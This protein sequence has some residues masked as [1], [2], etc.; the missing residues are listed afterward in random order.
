[1]SDNAL[2]RA[3]PKPRGFRLN[4]ADRINREYGPLQYDDPA[5]AATAEATRNAM[6]EQRGQPGVLSKLLIGGA[7]NALEA[8]GLPGVFDPDGTMR[9]QTWGNALRASSWFPQDTVEGIGQA[10]TAP[11]RAYRGE[12]PDEDMISEGLNF[13]GNMAIGGSAVPKGSAVARVAANASESAAPGAL[14]SEAARP[15]KMEV[16]FYRGSANGQ[17]AVD[18][19]QPYW[20]TTD[21]GLASDYAKSRSGM[22]FN[23][24]TTPNVTPAVARFRDPLYIDA[25]NAGWSDIPFEGQ[26]W[27]SDRLA[28]VA[29]E[30]GHDGLVIDRLYDEGRFDEAAGLPATVAALRPGTVSSAFDPNN[31]LY[32]NSKSSGVPGV[33]INQAG[34]RKGTSATAGHPSGVR[35]PNPL[36]SGRMEGGQ[37]VQKL[38]SDPLR[39]GRAPHTTIADDLL[40]SSSF[41]PWTVDGY[42]ISPAEIGSLRNSLA[43]H[44]VD[45]K[46]P[47]GWLV[48]GRSRRG[49]LDTGNVIQG[50]ESP[51]TARFY[52]GDKGGSIWAMRP[53]SS[54]NVLDFSG[55]NTPDIRKTAADALRS[56]RRGDLPFADDIAD[57]PTAEKSAALRSN[58]APDDIVNSAQA[59]DN[60]NWLSWLYDTRSPD[61]VKTPDGGVAFGPDGMQAIRLFANAKSSAA[62]G[63]L[64]SE[65]SKRVENPIRAYHGS[66]HD[67][68]KFDLSKIGT[69]EGAQA[70]GHGLYFAEREGVARSY[71]DALGGQ[72]LSDGSKFDDANPAHQ[73][74]AYIARTSSKDEAIKALVDDIAMSRRKYDEAHAQRLMRA[75]GMLERGEPIPTIGNGKMYE[76]SINADPNDFLDWDKP[77]SQQS[78]KVRTAM[79]Q[80]IGAHDQRWSEYGFK[81]ADETGSSLYREV[82]EQ[83]AEK[84]AG[85]PNANVSLSDSV[86]L[87]NEAERNNMRVFRE[88]GIPGIKYLDQGSR[89]AGEGSRNYV[90]FDDALIEI[91]RKYMNP[92]TAAAPGV[93]MVEAGKDQP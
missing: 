71:R 45:G 65:A 32:A 14:A 17:T 23:A 3:R 2:A 5:A 92:K 7:A 74:A 55:V 22:Y 50:S 46:V 63:V 77:L 49:D 36:L 85:G 67:F 90:V 73:A 15:V 24:D 61:F 86:R 19:N 41:A 18:Y 9:S 4:S 72:K 69:G 51:E 80:L 11:A 87:I 12:I 16:P 38:A 62:P 64:A 70:Y 56:Y 75:K 42:N 81:A 60:P 6:L 20:G 88:A 48:H 78:E 52:A 21:K 40:P 59:F 54:A 8:A 58:F 13:A 33:V 83:A 82:N 76:V 39:Q 30:R 84:A 91:L 47:D 35:E 26:K 89:T 57:L 1:M 29:K 37:P 53:T 34:E 27:N 79:S 28:E 43:E 93:L 68:D 44:F 10:I 31:I 25:Q 66:P